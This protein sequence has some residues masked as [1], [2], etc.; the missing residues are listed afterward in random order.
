MLHNCLTIGTD[1]G[2]ILVTADWIGQKKENEKGQ[3]DYQALTE[4]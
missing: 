2:D 3:S 1:R 4:S